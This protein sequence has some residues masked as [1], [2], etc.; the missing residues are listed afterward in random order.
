MAYAHLNELKRL[1]DTNGCVPLERLHDVYLEHAIF[2]VEDDEAYFAVEA[3]GKFW[4]IIGE[5]RGD[6]S[7]GKFIGQHYGVNQVYGF[8]HRDSAIAC[9][10]MIGI[11]DAGHGESINKRVV[12]ASAWIKAY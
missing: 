8:D 2:N 11:N 7:S 10:L 5:V 9:C 6:S 3:E 12:E 4:A 1:R